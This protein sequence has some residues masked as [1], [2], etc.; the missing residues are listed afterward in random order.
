MPEF[1]F[2]MLGHIPVW[3][4]GGLLQRTPLFQHR[5]SMPQSLD[6]TGAVEQRDADATF[7]FAR[8]V[9]PGLEGGQVRDPHHII[10]LSLDPLL[11]GHHNHYRSPVHQ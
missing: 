11:F 10:E 5:R 6:L 9:L 2:S 1:F 4:L 3:R 8:G 7:T